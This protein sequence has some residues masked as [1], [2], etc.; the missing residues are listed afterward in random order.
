MISDEILETFNSLNSP[1]EI[2]RFQAKLYRIKINKALKRSFSESG[3]LLRFIRY[4]WPVVEPYTI[5]IEG[6]PLTAMTEHLEA[7]VDGTIPPRLL[8]NIC[9][10]SMK[11]LLCSVFFP[12]WLWS[13][14]NQPGARFVCLSYSSDR[15]EKDNGKFINIIKSKEFQELYGKSFSLRRD[16]V[17]FVENDKTGF[18][19]AMGI[20]GSVTGQRGDYIIL[21]DPNNLA[22]NESAEVR[23]ET[24]RKFKE[25]IA[26]RLNNMEKSVIIVIQQRAH[27]EDVSGFILENKLPYVH[28]CVPALFEE[29]RKCITYTKDGDIF[30]EDPRT[31]FEENFWPERFPD[32]FIES[33]INIMDPHSFA[34]QYL[35]RPS[36]KDGGLIKLDYWNPWFP[37]P[38]KVIVNNQIRYSR[39]FPK[40]DFILASL[41]PAFTEKQHNDP[42]GFT[43]WGTFTH[44]R[45]TVKDGDGSRGVML[46]DSFTK[47]LEPMGTPSPLYKGE[48]YSDWKAR[49]EED[50]GLIETVH[51][52][53]K[54]YGVNVLLIEAVQAQ[55]TLVNM[56]EKLFPRRTFSIEAINP[57]GLDKLARVKRIQPIFS[58]GY[59]YAP[60]QAEFQW[61]DFVKPVI[62]ECINFPY[63]K[64]DDLVDS[65]TQALYWLRSNGFLERK[66]EQ[67]IKKED[68]AKQ[69]KFPPPL[70]QI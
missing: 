59:V 23:D 46:I 20:S 43:I 30:W 55:V 11:S 31:D 22:V 28:F 42:S 18:K 3:G 14:K 70:Y 15:P 10:G 16:G 48:T 2:K 45:D 36:P 57:K 67:F 33:Q 63:D 64:H 66:E 26:N 4:F 17:Q 24:N 12:L 54:R 41:D 58:G 35:Q 32:E 37:E 69:Y 51:D 9:P 44:N 68:K 25:A 47:R 50:W 62:D 8:I 38:S 13:A 65:T 21:D 56:M 52:R 53:C 39:Q 1:L 29:N 27:R 49:T 6:W 7:I 61:K 40:F 5:F 19:Q 60:C 34:G